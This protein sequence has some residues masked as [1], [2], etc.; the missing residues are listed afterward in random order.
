MKPKLYEIH[1]TATK[2]FYVYATSES[3]ALNHEMV[4]EES[5]PHGELNW[6]F[7][8]GEAREL[9]KDEAEYV[10][11]AQAL[12]YNSDTPIFE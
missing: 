9:R 8:E 4:N 6:Y 3:A 12:G 7:V 1:L 11:E 10:M 5:R 2:T